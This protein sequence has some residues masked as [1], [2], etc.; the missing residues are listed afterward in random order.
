MSYAADLLSITP[1]VVTNNV[2]NTITVKGTGFD[3]TAVV[4]LEG[5]AL[6][7]NFI[8]AETL[9]ALVPAGVRR[10]FLHRYSYPLRWTCQWFCGVDC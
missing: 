7:T 4:L 9:T 2:N 3:N 1:G 8:D 6:G 10:R 5:S